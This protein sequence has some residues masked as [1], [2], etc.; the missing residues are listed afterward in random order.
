[1]NKKRGK[2]KRRNRSKSNNSALSQHKMIGKKLLPPMLHM[3]PQ[4]KMKFSSWVNNRLP[5]VLWAALAANA[6]PREDLLHMFLQIAEQLCKSAHAQGDAKEFD[7]THSA[8]ELFPGSIEHLSAI[9]LEHPAG[10]SALRPLLLFEGIPA[11]DRWVSALNV[12]PTETDGAALVAAV[13]GCLDHQSQQSTDIRW[14][15]LMFKIG[16]G[17]AQFPAD[18]IKNLLRY[19]DLTPEAEE[20]RYIRPSIRAAEMAFRVMSP[21]EEEIES[22]WCNSF[23]M[24]CLERSQCA[25]YE[26]VGDDSPVL[27]FDEEKLQKSWF[28][29]QY[30]LVERFSQVQ[31][32]TGVDARFDAVFGIAL[33]AGNLLLEVMHGRNRIGISGRLLLRSLAECRITLSYLIARNDDVLWARFRQFGIGQAKLALLKFDDAVV[34]PKF[35]SEKALAIIAN[36][37][38]SEEFVAVDLGHWCDLDLRKMAEYADVKYEYDAYYG[39]SSAFVHGSWSAIRDASLATCIN[40]LHRLHR[41]PRGIQRPMEDVLEDAVGLFNRICADVDKVYAGA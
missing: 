37:D 20:M 30:E 36:E 6:L 22:P 32:T 26:G 7:L 9:L 16:A 29:K 28:E 4:E 5:E 35:L 31:A 11:R 12:E 25:P 24:E 33:F 41:V 8:L 34:P 3:L 21:N 19:L 27:L 17:K 15:T 38:A 13:G 40:P 39:W 2:T 10:L 14:L 23:W 18:M 1:M